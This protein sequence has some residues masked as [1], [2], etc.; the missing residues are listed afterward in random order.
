MLHMT[1][2][3]ISEVCNRW[4]KVSKLGE[5]KCMHIKLRDILYNVAYFMDSPL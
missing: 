4:R 1:L 2:A 5:N 3:Y